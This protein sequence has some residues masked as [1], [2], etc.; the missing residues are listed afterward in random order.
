ML[1]LSRKVG[2]ELIIG[3]NIRIK[4]NRLDAS[5]VSLAIDAPEDVRVLRGELQ[6]IRNG[7]EA[8]QAAGKKTAGSPKES[9]KEN[10]QGNPKSSPKSG[11]AGQI[12]ANRLR[13][14]SLRAV[15]P[16]PLPQPAT[17]TGRESPAPVDMAG[18]IE[19]LLLQAVGA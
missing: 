8:E 9:P 7:F 10:S 6:E 14:N 3:G 11:L 1:V 12:R 17:D 19:P 15:P 5:R 18:T 4:V 16:A 13:S 2:E